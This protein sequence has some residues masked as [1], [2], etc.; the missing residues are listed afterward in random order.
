MSLKNSPVC[1]Y[2]KYEFDAEETW[3]SAYSN[4]SRV[5]TGDGDESL[6]DC[7]NDDCGK[8][9]KVFCC[10]VTMF[11]SVENDDD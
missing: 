11:D 9:F 4:K 10:D 6:V 2:C 3:H 8:K 1:P 7:H 5:L